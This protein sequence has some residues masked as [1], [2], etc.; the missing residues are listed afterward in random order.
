M[1]NTAKNK[2]FV[3]IIATVALEVLF[4]RNE[5]VDRA[6]E[7][8]ENNPY[9]SNIEID[10]VDGAEGVICVVAKSG[11]ILWKNPAWESSDS[12]DSTKEETELESDL[13]TET[14]TETE[15][16]DETGAETE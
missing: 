11:R 4:D 9:G 15:A 6:S 3:R 16:W 1:K 8:G 2:G 13:E 5:P 12:E 10:V 7:G 14:E